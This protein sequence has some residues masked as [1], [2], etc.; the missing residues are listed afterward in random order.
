V[1]HGA[2]PYQLTSALRKDRPAGGLGATIWV[3]P[4]S[5]PVRRAQRADTRLATAAINPFAAHHR[6]RRSQ[7]GGG[8]AISLHE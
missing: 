1:L 3:A 8:H 5:V 2:R 7:F 4:A 6:E